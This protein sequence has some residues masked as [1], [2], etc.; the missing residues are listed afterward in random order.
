MGTLTQADLKAEL[1][2]GLGNRSDL[3]DR[4]TGILNLAQQAIVRE[5]AAKKVNYK[6]LEV[7]KNFNTVASQQSYIFESIEAALRP[8]TIYSLKIVQSGNAS[9]SQKLL[10]VTPS[11]MDEQLPDALLYG[12]SRPTAYVEW[13][14]QLDLYKIPDAIYNMQLKMYKWPTAFVSAT[15]TQVSDLDEKDDLLIFWSLEYLWRS[16]GKE[17]SERMMFAKYKHES[18]FSKY[19]NEANADNQIV[20]VIDPHHR[21]G[22]NGTLGEYWR[23]PLV[24]KI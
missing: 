3:D 19:E 4:L 2:A 12:E 20:V 21:R 18:V 13:A 5:A 6:E 23:D 16:L 9:D 24:R 8:R 15:T 22:Y 14:E 11:K 1:Q 17:E 10:K 7:T